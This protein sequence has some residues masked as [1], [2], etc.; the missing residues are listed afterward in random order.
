MAAAGVAINGCHMGVDLGCVFDEAN[1]IQ[2]SRHHLFADRC[3]ASDLEELIPAAI[4]DQSGQGTTEK[5]FHRGPPQETH[6]GL[7][8]K[9]G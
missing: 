6:Q 1:T 8:N 2:E 4:V 7:A 5:R 9:C 3:R